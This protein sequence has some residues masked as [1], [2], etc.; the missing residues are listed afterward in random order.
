MRMEC[1][2]IGTELLTTSRMDTNSVWLAERLA[3][4]GLGFQRKT[5]VGD[6]RE[7]LRGL[8][9]EA[10]QRSDWII[11]T[12]G[13]GPTFDDFT[14]DVWAEV[15][16]DELV[17]N[18]EAR[19]DLLAFFDARKRKPAST[20]FQQI[21]LPKG[22]TMLRNPVGTAPG[23]LWQDPVGWPGRTI[24]LLPGV[25][26]EMRS[27]WEHQIEPLL[28]GLGRPQRH[29]LRLVVGMVP[30]STLDER[31]QGLRKDHGHL[32]WTILSSY[33]HLELLAR[34]GDACALEAAR[35]DA[36]ALLGEDL[37][38]TGTGTIESTVLDLLRQRG[39]T[40]A[41]AESATGGSLASRLT[42]LPGASQAF[43]GGWIVYTRTAKMAL[44]GLSGAFLDLHGP[45]SVATTRALAEA[46]QARMESTWGLAVTGNAGPSQDAG[47]AAPVGTV[48]IALTGPGG[49]RDHFFLMP[50]HRQDVQARA[51][52]WGL[53]LLR[54]R[55]TRT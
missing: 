32:D 41:V 53:D 38:C 46:V 1:I 55:V 21:L 27:M 35:Q 24:V 29:T 50:G 34:S 7:A 22:G 14:K 37:V 10:L 17:E 16:G 30:E 52:S 39:E 45:V 40:L 49:T 42:A 9:T 23:V 33:T 4:F 20:N 44:A 12:G 48:H 8:F 43:L 51:A 15:L 54:R 5:A 47:S 31:T 18:E 3:A 28:E 26:R 11:C 25:P 2:A 36:V 6:D 19:R 13:L